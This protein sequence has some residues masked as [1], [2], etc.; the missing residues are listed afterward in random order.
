[1]PSWANLVRVGSAEGVEDL[2]AWLR[3]PS[4]HSQAD[5][6]RSRGSTACLVPATLT[7]LI[8]LFAFLCG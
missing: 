3:G 5:G 1:V 4:R 7:G 8:I 2:T 6:G